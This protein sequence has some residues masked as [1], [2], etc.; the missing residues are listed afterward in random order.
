MKLLGDPHLLVKIAEGNTTAYKEVIDRYS[1]PLFHYINRRINCIEDTQEILQD[2]F[3][4]LWRNAARISITQSLSP[5]LYQSAKF[6]TID[7]MIKHKRYQS[8]IARLQQYI[9]PNTAAPSNEELLMA[10]E[11]HLEVES[12]V[13]KMPTTMQKAFRMSRHQDMSI[14]EIAQHLAL[15]EQ[16]VKNNISLAL[17]RLRLRFK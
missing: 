5:Y 9:Q 6:E 13:E 2:I 15:S 17:N 12:E 11:L 8:K 4:S 16:T 7:W 3:H 1:T 10:E 14:K